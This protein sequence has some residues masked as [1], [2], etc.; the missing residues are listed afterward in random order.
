MAANY[1]Y[2]NPSTGLHPLAELLADGG[3]DCGNLS[4]IYISLLRCQGIPARH[5]VTINT[6]GEGHV[7]AEFYLERHGWIP[8]DVT[9]AQV[10]GDYFGKIAASFNGIVVAKDIDL[11]IDMA[12][13]ARRVPLLQTYALW[14][15]SKILSSGTIQS[16]YSVR[17]EKIES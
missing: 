13:A 8:V 16:Q 1:R 12:G 4:S 15:W 3:G 6:N 14:Y 2:L 17:A 10:G 9:M 11:P 7:W 5:V